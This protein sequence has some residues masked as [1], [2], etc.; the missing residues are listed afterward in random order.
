M[1]HTDLG[2]GEIKRRLLQNLAGFFESDKAVA[3]SVSFLKLRHHLRLA[4]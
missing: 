1:E 2:G 3:V 4:V